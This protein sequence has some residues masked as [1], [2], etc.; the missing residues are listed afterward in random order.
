MRKLI[1]L[2]AIILPCLASAAGVEPSASV[3]DLPLIESLSKS[4]DRP[5]FAVLISGD[6][7]WASI[8][9]QLT[10]G[11]VA[12]GVSV[13]GLNARSYFWKRKSPAAAG[14]DLQRILNYYF[15]VWNKAQ[16][17]LIGYSRGAD[18]LGCFR[19]LQEQRQQLARVRTGKQGGSIPLLQ[20]PGQLGLIGEGG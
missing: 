10:K 12:K 18:V 14:E 20:R 15:S 6:G 16:V 9:R 11:L 4:A 7:G 13:V 1:F 5:L 17:I 19:Q 3:D 8:D 2:W